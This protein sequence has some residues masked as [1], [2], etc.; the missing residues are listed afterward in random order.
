MNATPSLEQNE[1]KGDKRKEPRWDLKVKW[2]D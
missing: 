2:H 1:G